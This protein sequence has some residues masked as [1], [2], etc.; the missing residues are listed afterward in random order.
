[1]KRMKTFLIY[2]LLV[3]SVVLL[4]DVLA[5]LILSSG[6]KS[7]KN[8]EILTTSP[9]I[10]ITEAKGTNVDGIIEGIIKNETE[11]FMEDVYIKIELKS[12]RGVT[13]GTEYENLGNFQPGQTKE[14]ELRYR[15]SGVKTFT[16]SSVNEEK[17]EEL[18]LSPV[19]E[20]VGT[21]YR[22]SRLIVWAVTPAYY[23][24]PLFLFTLR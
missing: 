4:T 1:M 15:Y 14:F 6:K 12:E 2:A 9:T 23:F 5:N 20:N 8:Y 24:I 13:L 19:L 21:I 7:L 16:I 3:I 11:E 22:V 10:E 18:K 17:K